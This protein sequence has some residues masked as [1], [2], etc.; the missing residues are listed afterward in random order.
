MILLIGIYEKLDYIDFIYK[1][2]KIIHHKFCLRVMILW[3][4]A[5]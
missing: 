4:I 5:D 3:L 1:N 2:G